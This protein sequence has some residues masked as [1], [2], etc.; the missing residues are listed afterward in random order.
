MSTNIQHK[1][2]FRIPPSFYYIIE[3]TMHFIVFFFQ[4]QSFFRYISIFFFIYSFLNIFFDAFTSISEHNILLDSRNHLYWYEIFMV[5]NIKQFLKNNNSN[6]D[7]ENNNFVTTVF[8]RFDD[9]KIKQSYYE[10]YVYVGHYKFIKILL[11]IIYF[12]GIT[13]KNFYWNS[14]TISKYK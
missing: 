1:H 9:Y 2:I 7:E 8:S 4:Y 3:Y 11:W 13:S 12:L 6:D 14:L 5:N 10:V